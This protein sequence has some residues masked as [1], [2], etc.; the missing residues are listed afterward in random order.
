MY[1]D[2]DYQE[3]VNA[4]YQIPFDKIRLEVG[5]IDYFYLCIYGYNGKPGKPGIQLMFVGSYLN[6]LVEETDMPLTKM[7]PKKFKKNYAND[8][9]V[10]WLCNMLMSQAQLNYII[11]HPPKESYQ[12]LQ[13][14]PIIQ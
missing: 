8:F 11:E 2:Y 7:E 1:D 5:T 3:I 13:Q 12:P 6:H 10:H 4:Y 14:K 9:Q